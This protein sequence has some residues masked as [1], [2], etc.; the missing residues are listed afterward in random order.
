[1]Q[2]TYFNIFQPHLLIMGQ[3]DSSPS[4]VCDG[5]LANK[6]NIDI[7]C[8]YIYIFNF[9]TH[10]CAVYIYYIISNYMYTATLYLIISH[11]KLLVSPCL[12]LKYG[13][14]MLNPLE[15]QFWSY[16]IVL[17][18]MIFNPIISNLTRWFPIKKLLFSHITFMSTFIP[19][20]FRKTINY[21]FIMQCKQRSVIS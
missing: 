5:H 3:S 10:T 17:Y 12:S 11:P 7:I 16:V 13:K 8:I 6:A 18:S 14:I 9:I 1:M 19:S 21:P 4:L 20:W 2:L 15:S